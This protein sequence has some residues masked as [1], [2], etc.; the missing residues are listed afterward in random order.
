MSKRF[1]AGLLLIG[2]A[3]LVLLLS[4]SGSISLNLL[5]KDVSLQKSVALFIYLAGGVLIGFL[6]R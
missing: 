6:L 3:V 1:M 5:V 2:V 4:G